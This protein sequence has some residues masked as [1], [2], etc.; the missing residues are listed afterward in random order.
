MGEVLQNGTAGVHPISIIFALKHER[1]GSLSKVMKILE[2]NNLNLTHIESRHIQFTANEFLII[3]ESN[4]EELYRDAMSA[5][6]DECQYFNVIPDSCKG[7][8]WF[9]RTMADLEV[10]SKQILHYGVELDADH[11]GFKDRVYRQRRKSV[12][13]LSM[14][15][16]FG[17]PIPR[18]EYTAEE[19]VTWN[20][21]FAGLKELHA[22]HA[23]REYKEIKDEMFEACGYRLDNVPQLED[24]SKYISG[25]H[26]RMRIVETC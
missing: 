4:G 2:D 15:Y 3:F 7:S 11:P 14:D 19:V 10:I 22:T 18:I 16:K 26:V 12:A 9:P 20:T 21:C 8:T 25:K 6:S 17:D 5:I 1:S 24:V 23:C 13:D